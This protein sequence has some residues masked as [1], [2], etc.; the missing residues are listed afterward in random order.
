MEIKNEKAS[1][2][3]KPAVVVICALI[4]CALWGSATPFIKT[5]Y[6]LLLPEKDV[7]S[8][9]LFAG[10]R[11]ALAGVITVMIYS[12]A[13]RR[14][15]YPKKEN[16]PRVLLVGVFQTV[17]QYIFFYVG[18]ANT[19][20]VKGTIASGTSAFFAVLVAS[21][22]FRQEKL[23]VK[24]IVACVLGFAGIVVVN[25]DGLDFTMN[26][27]GDAFVIFS[28]I[29]LAFSSVLIKR[30]SK[31][32]DPVVISGYQFIAGGIFMVIVGL[33][34]GGKIVFDESLGVLVL[35]YLAFLSAVAY[36]LWGML[37]KHNPVSK[38]SVFSF[39]TPIFG[40]ILSEIMLT[41]SSG[42]HWI[43]LVI[44]LALVSSGIFLLNFQRQKKNDLPLK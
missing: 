21:L 25:L 31:Y 42:V 38:V 7:P 3:T 34:F 8:T 23:T 24:K 20:G 28:A 18:L 32:E 19:T 4:C 27:F 16:I 40:T 9:I 36:A 41:E 6:E 35:A 10:I 43:N 37:L 11:F 44:T 30:F 29:S 12:I 13:R 15:L 14:V 17:V 1:V 33:V 2:F 22:I 5:G 39:T 26:F